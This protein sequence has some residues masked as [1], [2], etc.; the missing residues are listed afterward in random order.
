VACAAILVGSASPALA[1]TPAECV[2]AAERA[3]T[4][5]D[6]GHLLAS[7]VEFV[8]CAADSCPTVVKRECLRWLAEVDERIPSLQISVKERSGKDVLGAEVTVDGVAFPNA[9]TGRALQ[10]DPGPHKIRAKVAGR[11]PIEEAIIARERERD[12]VVV[13]ALAADPTASTDRDRTPASP[14]TPVTSQPRGVPVLSWVL[15]GV[16]VA[17][18]GAFAYFWASGTGRVSDLRDSC[19]PFCTSE[20]IDD[21]RVPLTTARIALAVG[22]A[23]GIGAVIVYL[24]RPSAT[25]AA[26]PGGVRMTAG[27]PL[28]FA[29]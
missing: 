14:V 29:F 15:G 24:V 18:V 12:R 10:L 5:R 8:A 11:E 28:T 27:A 4:K 6:E 19:S 9:G 7:R 20:Q 13:L 23:A 22:V 3:Q 17:G 16:A 2:A 25:S 1:A 21:A 26:A